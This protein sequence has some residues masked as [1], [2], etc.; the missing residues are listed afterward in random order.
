MKKSLFLILIMLLISLVA[1]TACGKG[2]ED[3]ADDGKMKIMLTCSEGFTVTS[4]NPVIANPGEPVSFEV[5]LADGYVFANLN[6]GDYEDGVVTVTGMTKSTVIKLLAVDLGYSTSEEYRYYFNGEDSDTTSVNSSS[7]VYGGDLV[8]VKANETYKTFLGWSF[9]GR[10]VDPNEMFS[11]DR[12]YTFRISPSVA[13]KDNIVRIYANY[14][15]SGVYYY[16]LNGGE[17]NTGTGNTAQNKYYILS[18][19]QEKIKVTMSGDYLEVFAAVPLF[20]DDGSFTRDGYILKEYNTA[21]DGTGEGYSPGSRYL[22][23]NKDGVSNVLYCIWE[24]AEEEY[25]SYKPFNYPCPTDPSRATHWHEE[26]IM[27]TYYSG[28]ESTVAIPEMIDGKYVTGIATG[29]FSARSFDTLVLPRTIQR[30][31]KNAFMRCSSLETIYL[32]DSI[33]DMTNESFDSESYTSLKNIYVGA[34]MAPRHVSAYAVKLSRLMETYDENRI[35]VIAGSSVYQGLSSEYLGALLDNDYEVINFGTTR[36]THGLIYLEAMS[37]YAHEGDIILYAPENSSYMLGETQLY[38]KTLRDMESF[39]NLYRCVDFSNYTNIFSAFAD[40]NQRER[41]KRNPSRY[42]ASYDTIV[43]NGH[44]INEYGEYQHPDRTG[45]AQVYT[46]SYHITLNNRVKSRFEAAWDDEE[47]QE[48]MKDYNDPEN[49][50][51]VSID[52]PE[53]M[54]EVNRVIAKAKLSGAGVY[55]SFCPVDADKVVPEAQNSAWMQEYDELIADIYDFDGVLG[56]SSDYVFAHVYFYDNAF[57][58]N[59]VG[60]AFRTYRVYLDLAE[61]LKIGTPHG[62]TE[63]GAD[64]EG[65]IFEGE[66]G[67]PKNGVSYL[68]D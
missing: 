64:F 61:L 20:W 67:I 32:P 68:Q 55:F 9:N 56:K 66:S 51:W 40:F 5:E 48:A 13:N 7:K 58:L 10:T 16:D 19:M 45:L 11:T 4:E 54:N 62:F 59:D 24:R 49:I 21:P 35:I 8:T 38:W 17:Y 33:Y 30:I 28:N 23:E 50:T 14:A 2:G 44:N 18:E 39:Y 41:Y 47:V 65:C 34:T 43:K 52:S 57:H 26:G 6:Y 27:I 29:A 60:R 36:T 31:E 53:L 46:D 3:N 42:E 22:I 1:L 37:K 12:E 15:E 25:F 63:V